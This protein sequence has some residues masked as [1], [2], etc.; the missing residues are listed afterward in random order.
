MKR[1]CFTL[2]ALLLS[3]TCG[4]PGR[5]AGHPAM[6]TV[7]L[8][9]TPA[10][11]LCAAWLGAFNQP[12]REAYSAFVRERLPS[13]AEHLEEE[14]EFRDMT[15]GF[16]LRKVEES[17]PT[18]LVALVQE[19]TSDVFARLVLDVDGA[20]PQVIKN[21]DLRAIPRPAAFALPAMSERELVAALEKK[22]DEEAAAGRFAGAVLLARGGTVVFARAYGLA[23]RE[24][25][26]ANTLTTRFRIG[27]M[28]KMFTATAILQLVQA[29][30]V[31]LD[32]SVGT[33]LPDYPNKEVASKVTIRHLLTHTGG[34]ADIFGPEFEA[35]RLQLRTLDDY[36]QLY[37]SRAPEFEPGSR[38]AYSNYGFILLGVVIAKV[39]GEDYYQYVLEHIYQPVGMISSGSDP[40]ETAVAGRSI[41]YTR[42]G[43]SGQWRPNGDT[44]PYRGTS[45]GGGYSTV[46]DLLRFASALQ[47]HTLLDVE[48][49][50]LLTTGKVDTPGGRYGFGFSE[51]T[52]NG[53]RCFGHGGGAPGMSGDLKVCPDT[54][55]V[56]AVL[57]NIDPIAAGRISDFIANRLPRPRR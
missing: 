24:H 12:D 19:R 36:V 6:A 47:R 37:G 44:L 8:P 39:S 3:A 26:V 16:E 48:H 49:T 51:A 23:D 53:T 50:V 7:E 15:G 17:S 52:I 20:A 54:G 46:E 30:K 4:S 42:L 22:L 38:F 28:N 27:S 57:A 1:A 13:R 55:Y 11:R 21:L 2:V 14:L 34:T 33:Y 25:G 32:Q 43:G 5:R 35:R 18:R 40:E 31:A 29:G 56:I 10:G 9:D 41:G 45:A